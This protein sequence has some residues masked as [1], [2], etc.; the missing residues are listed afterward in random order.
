M[1]IDDTIRTDNTKRSASSSDSYDNLEPW[2]DKLAGMQAGTADRIRL[3]EEIIA[4]AM[5]MG[6]HIARRYTGRGV[7]YED[8]AQVAALG[9]VLAVDRFDPGRGA[10]FIGFAVPT[11]MG[12]VKRYFRDSTWAVRVP[13]A[14][15]DTQQ[16]VSV[17]IPQL[18]QRLGRNPTARELAEHL[19]LDP[20][21][22]TQALIA[23]NA[24]RADSLDTS[25]PAEDDQAPSSPITSL[26]RTDPGYGLIEDSLTVG[27]LLAA[28]PT[29]DRAVLTLRYGHNHTQAQIARE[30]G[31]SQMHVSR[32]LTRILSQLHSKALPPVE[33]A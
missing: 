19:R 20:A 21:E 4:L 7:E 6:E 1:A 29:R 3:R 33:A 9:V 15:K 26:G 17:A 2:F 22:I 5:P 30:L 11:I 31:V 27:P 14:V 25:E 12:E 24:Y 16:R 13:R 23:N 10:T 32:M 18:F 28:M 8:L